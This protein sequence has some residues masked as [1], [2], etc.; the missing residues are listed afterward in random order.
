MLAKT[1]RCPLSQPTK[2]RKLQKRW[3]VFTKKNVQRLPELHENRLDHDI[4]SGYEGYFA[5]YCGTTPGLLHQMV[6]AYYFASMSSASGC[7]PASDHNIMKFA[8]KI[9]CF[10]NNTMVLYFCQKTIIEK[11]KRFEN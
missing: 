8:L 4:R 11:F 2:Y 7:M 3:A 1:S 10:F 5:E 6:L 9:H